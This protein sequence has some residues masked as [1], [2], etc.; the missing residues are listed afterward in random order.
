MA[1]H[2]F[3]NAVAGLAVAAGLALGSPAWQP[4]WGPTLGATLAG[5][6]TPRPAAAAGFELTPCAVGPQGAAAECGHLTVPENRALK[7]GRR[8]DI[9]FTVVRALRPGARHALF[10]FAGGPGGAGTSLASRA[11]GWAAPVRADQDIVLVDQRGTGQSHSLGFGPRAATNPR[12]PS[13]MSTTRTGSNVLAPLSRRR[14]TSRSTSPTSPL[15]TSRTSGPGWAT[16]RSRCTACRS[17]RAWRRP[18]CAAIPIACAPSSWTGSSPLTA[19]GRSPSRRPASRRSIARL[20]R[21]PRT[22]RAGR[23]IR[24]RPTTS[25]R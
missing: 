7:G 23:R 5:Q 21:A 9:H 14:R 11:S 19:S 4:R 17:A 18:T 10:M 15:Q 22:P 2:T 6:E 12:L 8:L 3:G 24:A 25:T 13:A 20:R 1:R 16:R